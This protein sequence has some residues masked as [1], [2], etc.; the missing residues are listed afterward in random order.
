MAITYQ[1]QF[2]PA[3]GGAWT[4]LFTGRAALSYDWGWDAGSVP[5]GSYYIRVRA[6]EDG[7]PGDWSPEV[8]VTL[9]RA[10][11]AG[12]VSGVDLFCGDAVVH[13]TGYDDPDGDPV[14]GSR[15]RVYTPGGA[16]VA[17]SGVV[18]D[19][20]LVYDYAFLGALP[21]ATD[22]HARVQFRSAADAWGPESAPFAFTT[23]NC[24]RAAPGTRL[25]HVEAWSD[26]Q[27]AGGVRLA[28][29]RRVVA[30]STRANLQPGEEQMVVEMALDDPLM[31]HLAV[32]GVLRAFYGDGPSAEYRVVSVVRER[33]ASNAVVAKAAADSIRLDL[34]AT[35]A[36]QV[37]ANGQ[38]LHSWE[39][40]DLT[41]AEHVQRILAGARPYFVLGAIES[42]ERIMLER[43]G[44]S[45]SQLLT[46]AERLSLE[47][48]VARTSQGRYEVRLVAERGAGADVPLVMYGR[49]LLGARKTESGDRLVTRVFPAGQEVEGVRQGIAGAQWEVAAIDASEAG[50]HRLQLAD[51]P[52]AFD[53]Q[54]NGRF[55]ELAGTGTR[56]E[57]LATSNAAQEVT[58]ADSAPF[59]VGD[60]V[61]FRRDAA[62]TELTLLERPDA[63]EA[64]GVIEAEVEFGDIPP[65]DN[66]LGDAFLTARSG[67][68]LRPRNW[69][70]VGAPTVSLNTVS[71]YTRF[72]SASWRSQAAQDEGWWSSWWPIAPDARRPYASASGQ[73]FVL[74]GRVRMVVQFRNAALVVTPFTADTGTLLNQWPDADKALHHS[75]IDVQAI[76][77]REFRIGFF[78]D[79]GP[80][81]WYLDAAVLVQASSVPDQLFEGLASNALHRLG[82]KHLRE[83]GAPART[84]DVVPRDLHR[85][86]PARFPHEAL[87][88]GGRVRVVDPLVEPD[89][90]VRINDLGADLL[91]LGT[92]ALQLDT[93]PFRLTE[94]VI[95]RALLPRRAARPVD[96]AEP[97]EPGS[98]TVDPGSISNL[99]VVAS[100]TTG[101]V[102]ISWDHNA[103]VQAGG[104][105][106]VVEVS[107]AYAAGAWAVIAARDARWEVGDVDA[108]TLKGGAADVLSV[109]GNPDQYLCQVR[110][111]W[112]RAELKRAGNL[113]R[114]LTT[115]IRI[116]LNEG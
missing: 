44:T 106:Y 81:D 13:A 55:L 64:Y 1:G 104:G 85:L 108:V 17:D 30:V 36:E 48:D 41:P 26:V 59:A 40:W 83:W 24:T 28:A 112:Y 39:D 77:A 110:T 95:P 65:V 18:T 34:N 96:E 90:T 51:G 57:I 72:G 6:V 62:G 9:D 54:F 37:Q 58:V 63:V 115:S 66:L 75:G 80:A 29:T 69:A 42:A 116:R 8:L 88:I 50:A 113:I 25:E 7:T 21:P 11:R 38:V 73:V 12:V 33:D 45:M 71:L 74:S 60:L 22:L 101:D 99:V 10:P 114:S 87:V 111:V 82:N 46:L 56:A 76:G 70:T 15:F 16:L 53:H 52:I 61:I 91:E 97:E 84:Y 103:A 100:D 32:G 27:A 79:G 94:V 2:R 23:R 5:S 35:I 107:R 92:T 68:P 102:A 98:G 3:A 89:A 93:T 86:E 4:T 109:C 14:T 67:T 20:G 31:Q 43:R 19:P 78:A 105:A 47:L 49:N